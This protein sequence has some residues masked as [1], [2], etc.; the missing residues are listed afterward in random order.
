[1]HVHVL[2]Y[3]YLEISSPVKYRVR[4]PNTT[5]YS[6]I[7]AQ[8]YAQN[9]GS[10]KDDFHM[11]NGV[12][13]DICVTPTEFSGNPKP[14]E[15]IYSNPDIPPACVVSSPKIPPEQATRPNLLF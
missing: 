5:E 13:E 2:L 3:V 11:K 4:K 6:H 9:A 10:Y 8:I 14:C 7:V 12:S 1:M 15:E